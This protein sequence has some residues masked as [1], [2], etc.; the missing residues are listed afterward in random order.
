MTMRPQQAA[1]PAVV[2]AAAGVVYVA[3]ILEPLGLGVVWILPGLVVAL[4]VYWIVRWAVQGSN[5]RPW[6]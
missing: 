2:G 3:A 4:A 6:D 5:L 1:I